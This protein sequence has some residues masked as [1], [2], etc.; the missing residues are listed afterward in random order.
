MSTPTETTTQQI[1]AAFASVASAENMTVTQLYQA[2]DDALEVVSTVVSTNQQIGR[3]DVDA[4]AGIFAFLE[5]VLSGRD[6]NETTSAVRF[7]R[8]KSNEAS[9]ISM[10]ADPLIRV[11]IRHGQD[12]FDAVKLVRDYMTAVK[13]RLT[14]DTAIADKANN[15]RAVLSQVLDPSDTP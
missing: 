15:F 13:L 3:R 4:I 10:S 11:G 7:I 12:H 5:V 1:Q 9:L 14:P 2:A 6:I 8:P